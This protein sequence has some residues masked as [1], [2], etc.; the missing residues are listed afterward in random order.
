MTLRC[1]VTWCQK[2]KYKS[3]ARCKE[4]EAQGIKLSDKKI[5]RGTGASTGIVDDTKYGV[6]LY[7]GLGFT[8]LRETLRVHVKGKGRRAVEWTAPD[9]NNCCWATCPNCF[10]MEVCCTEPWTK[11]IAQRALKSFFK[12]DDF[13]K[14][15]VGCLFFLNAYDGPPIQNAPDF[16]ENSLHTKRRKNAKTSQHFGTLFEET[17]LVMTG[18]SPHHYYLTITTA[19]TSTPANIH[20]ISQHRL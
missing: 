11:E 16:M 8:A 17:C 5:N 3:R 13:I 6:D 7:L 12:T 20:T 9:E 2:A 10:L 15:R 18:V 19:H 4:C 14:D 1:G